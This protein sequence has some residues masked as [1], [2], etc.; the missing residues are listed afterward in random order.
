MK[1]KSKNK[2]IRLQYWSIWDKD[3]E[4]L[5]IPRDP[6]LWSQ[7]NVSHWLAWAI[8]EFSLQGP[9]IDTFV[10]HLK[11]CGRQVCSISKEEFLSRAPCSLSCQTPDY[12]TSANVLMISML[13][14]SITIA[15]II[16]TGIHN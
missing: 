3:S 10:D 16:L 11:M 9:H 12:E 6:R 7:E 13:I 5:G 1:I 4:R 2:I 14:S 15:L 8:R